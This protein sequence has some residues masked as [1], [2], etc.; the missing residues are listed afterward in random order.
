MKIEM[1]FN[2]GEFNGT[3]GLAIV[4]NNNTIVNIDNTLVGL[5]T[6]TFDVNDDFE[7]ETFGKGPKDTLVKNNV[8]LLDKFIDLQYIKVSTFKLERYHLYHHFFNPYISKN[9][10][11]KFDLPKENI[12]YWYTTILENHAKIK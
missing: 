11:I 2:A 9:A 5:N 6:I 1:S 3:M 7:I 10:K 12:L 8:V 4:S